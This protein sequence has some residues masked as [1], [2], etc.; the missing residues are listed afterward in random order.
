[1]QS[2]TGKVTVV[3]GASRGLGRGI[4]IVLGEAGAT[5]YVTGRSV[6]GAPT[7]T[8]APE[9]IEETAEMVTARGG[10]GIPVRCD[11]TVDTEVE[12]LFRRVASE[13]GRLDLLVNNAWGGYENMDGFD[14]P[15]WELPAWRWD[16]MFR[17][18]VRTHFTASRSAVPLM[19]AQGHGLIV[20][21]AF[22]DHD[23]Y[24]R[25]LVQDVAFATMIRLAYGMALELRPHNIAAIALSP[26]WPRTEA[27]YRGFHTDENHWTEVPELARTESVEYAGRAVVALATDPDIMNDSGC[28]LTAG[29]LARR[30]S[31]TDVDGRY[32]PPYT[33]DE[34]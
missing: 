23:R 20:G 19:L 18:G 22:W 17:A 12:A 26:G 25:P 11:L 32:V 4:A 10:T 27:I 16:S 6:R 3:T 29:D 28:V 24:C 13:H 8:G 2:L 7:P 34:A 14:V 33:I 31:F 21:T 15:F 5:V 30:Y 9:T 1:M